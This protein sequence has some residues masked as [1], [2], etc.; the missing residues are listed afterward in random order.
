MIYLTL[1]YARSWTVGGALIRAAQWFGRYS[2]VAI[3]TVDGTV[4]DSTAFHGVR[5]TFYDEWAKRY[6]HIKTVR[7]EC[8][9]PDAGI[10]WAR[11]RVGAGYDYR[12][13]ANF[14]LRKLGQDKARWHCVEFVETAVAMAGRARFRGDA[15]RI[16]PHQSYTVI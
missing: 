16:T 2:H 7:V 14:I 1:L 5:E 9:S 11:S 6:S 3:L 12:A 8:P 4:I 13:V 15:S 10:T